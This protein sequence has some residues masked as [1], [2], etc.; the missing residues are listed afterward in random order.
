MLAPQPKSVASPDGHLEEVLAAQR[1]LLA[2]A[3]DPEAA[4][5][6]AAE[7]ACRITGCEAAA[8][9]TQDGDWLVRRAAS[10]QDTAADVRLPVSS[11]LVGLCY[12]SGE[13]QL[14]DDA[15]SDARAVP[16]LARQLG[17]RSVLAVP[18]PSS[19]AIEGVLRVSAR[20][21]GAFSTADAKL[22]EVVGGMIGAAL[23]MATLFQRAQKEAD[24]IWSALEQA[25][26][27]EQVHRVLFDEN[28]TPMFV[29][30]PKTLAIVRANT[31][32]CQLYGYAPAEFLGL[33]V[34][35]LAAEREPAG[36]RDAKEAAEGPIRT[37]EG[38]HRRKDGTERIVAVVA[39][40]FDLDGRA[41]RLVIV[42]DITERRRAEES[43]AATQHQLMQADKMA[44]VGQLAAGV[45]HEI[46]NPIG[47]VYSNLGTLDKYIADLLALLD[48]YGDAEGA[49]AAE[50]PVLGRIRARKQQIDLAFLREDVTALMAESREG[51]TRVKKIVQD[52][53]DFSHADRVD[54]WQTADLHK[55]LDSTLNIAHNELKYKCTVV[56]EYGELPEIEC[57][58]SQ[59]NQVFL[60]LLVN[61]AHAIQDKGTIT[62]RTGMRG[63]ALCVEISDSGCG[64]SKENLKRIFDPFFTTKPV[65]KGTGLGLSLSYGIVKKHGGRI[66]VDSEP[67]KGSR[68]RVLL[69]PRRPGK[70]A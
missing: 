9:F 3:T 58:P 48:L 42:S 30:D 36:P 5:A 28:P 23:E 4:L 55:G 56:K 31:A 35:A 8:V 49:L 32:A 13:V 63:D 15:E 14:C 61:A 50:G 16:N 18:L 62:V 21:A 19:R 59:L 12:R 6:Y 26:K 25:Q 33:A 40:G 41:T 10:G 38:R 22:M 70:A 34:T 29:Y 47:Y 60:N 64:I 39:H 53:K 44:S 37:G 17:V 51:I 43:L 27:S 11:S 52:L 20:R 46:N 1:E 68:F 2:R 54:D 45:A 67:G 57:L 66:E 24:E 69:P 65:G 7:A